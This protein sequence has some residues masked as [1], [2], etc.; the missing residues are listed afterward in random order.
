MAVLY[1]IR[2]GQASFGMDNYDLLTEIGRQ[3]CT[4]L[5]SHFNG[6]IPEQGSLFSGSMERHRQSA[7]QAF[8]EAKAL[9]LLPGLN[10]FDHEDILKVY[11]P[12]LFDRQGRLLK[13]SKKEEEEFIR[14][15]FPAAMLQWVGSASG[16]EYEESFQHFKSRCRESLQQLISRARNEQRKQL[17]AVS[18]GGVIS[19]LLMQILQ[20]P[21]HQ[22]P[23]LNLNIANASVSAF[24]F[25]DKKISLSYF[26][27]HSH[28]PEELVT[29]R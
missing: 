25:N 13:G 23:A 7:A 12:K 5:P 26:N 21:D 11:D 18:S 17:L 24:L 28:L 14:T 29:Y 22:F 10:E 6:I 15:A 27:N 8:P 20:I 19:L 16:A 4:F 3:Q 1:L 9:E 2:H